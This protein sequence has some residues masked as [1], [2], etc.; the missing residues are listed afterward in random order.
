MKKVEVAFLSFILRRNA[1]ELR[2]EVERARAR[3]VR[4]HVE[5]TIATLYA[6][7]RQTQM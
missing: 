5:F 1:S 3:V 7:G 2:A 4:I 6:F